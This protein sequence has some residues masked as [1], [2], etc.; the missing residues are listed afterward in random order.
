MDTLPNSECWKYHKKPLP[1]SR[2]EAPR[3]G[4]ACSQL[5]E[6]MAKNQDLRF[7]ARR[8]PPL[9]A[10]QVRFTE[11]DV[12]EPVPSQNPAAGEIQ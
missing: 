8:F 4:G 11:Y 5:V 3:K 2:A 6:L 10:A 12:L 7:E 9:E 1:L